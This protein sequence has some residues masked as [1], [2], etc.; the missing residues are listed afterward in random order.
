MMLKKT[1]C[2][3]GTGILTV[4]FYH[5]EI[6]KKVDGIMDKGLCCLKGGLKCRKRLQ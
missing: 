6:K 3:S 5:N 2:K 4:W 1:I